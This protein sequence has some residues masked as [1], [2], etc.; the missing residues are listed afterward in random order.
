MKQK[1]MVKYYNENKIAW[2]IVMFL[3][4][5][6]MLSMSFND[7]Y[8]TVRSSMNLWDAVKDGH[9]LDYYAYCEPGMPGNTWTSFGR[10]GSGAA[11]YDATIY[12]IFAIWNLPLWIYE[13]IQGANAFDSFALLFY[14]KCFLFIL[15]IIVSYYSVKILRFL[16]GENIE[17]ECAFL[18]SLLSSTLLIMYSLYT[19]NYDILELAFM[20]A[21]TYYFLCGKT[22]AFFISYS[23]AISIKYLPLFAFVYLVLLR[24]KK[25]HV[26]LGSFAAGSLVTVVEKLIFRPSEHRVLLDS[27]PVNSGLSFLL[28]PSIPLGGLSI[29]IYP[30]L[31]VI[32]GFYIWLKCDSQ[33]NLGVKTIFFTLLPYALLYLLSNPHPQWIVLVVPFALILW[34]LNPSRFLINNVLGMIYTGTLLIRQMLFYHWVFAQENFTGYLPYH[35]LGKKAMEQRGVPVLGY[36][37]PDILKLI[38]AKWD[39]SLLITV[40]NI[41]TGLFLIFI[42]FPWN[43]RS[44][45]GEYKLPDNYRK[46]VAIRCVVSWILMIA[47]VSVYFLEML[48]YLVR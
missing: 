38:Q 36:S 24:Y 9:F 7:F 18:L 39:Y 1:I 23:F 37:M 11:A 10:K 26:I 32:L 41:A 12:L 30:V 46:Q 13:Q 34:F 14:S 42:N 25:I 29:P 3:L 33:K 16:L 8:A 40:L 4:L 45:Q 48:V 6:I 20:I 15:L 31:Y 27:E 21:G 47:P 28:T 2:I 19:G 44:Y 22:I 17:R 5:I 43:D 35:L